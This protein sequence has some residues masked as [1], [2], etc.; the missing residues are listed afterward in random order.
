MINATRSS[1]APDATA[2][3]ATNKQP[4]TT[5]YERDSLVMQDL[6]KSLSEHHLEMRSE[7][8]TSIGLLQSQLLSGDHPARLA[9]PPVFKAKVA[10]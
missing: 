1:L 9:D 10:S 6:S 8:R 2:P 7:C 5:L 4:T 3:N